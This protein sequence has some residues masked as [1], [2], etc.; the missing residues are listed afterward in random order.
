METNYANMK[1]CILGIQ[2]WTDNLPLRS[3]KL[4]VIGS[5]QII[6][7]NRIRFGNSH[8]H[9]FYSP[10]LAGPLNRRFPHRILSLRAKSASACIIP[11]RNKLEAQKNDL[12][13][14]NDFCI[15]LVQYFANLQTKNN[16]SSTNE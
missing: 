1:Y 7:K 5:S 14:N 8:S 11:F 6:S 15:L 4:S 3:V 12:R 13:G 16:Y 9:H 10:N 2:R